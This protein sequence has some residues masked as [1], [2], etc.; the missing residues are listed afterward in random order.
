[1]TIIWEWRIFIF[2]N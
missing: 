1:L 2:T